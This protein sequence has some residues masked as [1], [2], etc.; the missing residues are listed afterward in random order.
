[1]NTEPKYH[2]VHE[3]LAFRKNNLLRVNSEYQRGAVWGDAQKR[4]LVDSVLRGYPIPLF[5]LHIVT[6]KM[7]SLGGSWL[8]VIDGQQ[9][10][11]ALDEFLHD[12][13]ALFD[14]IKDDKQARFPNFIKDVPCTW[15]RKTFSQLDSDDKARFLN[16]KLQV[17]EIETDNPNEARDLFIRLQAGLP[18]NSQ[19]KRDAWPG[20]LTELVLRLAGKGNLVGKGGHDF[21]KKFV[22]NTGTDRGKGRQLCAQ[23]LML[24]ISRR[25]HR[26]S[27]PDIGSR[28]L[29]EFYYR[30]LDFELQGQVATR[31]QAVLDR[32]ANI[33]GAT[34][35][36]KPLKG[37]EAIGVILLIDALMD[38]YTKG[39]EDIFV[40]A[41]LRF[42]QCVLND[43]ASRYSSE[44]GP[45]W[46][47]YDALTRVDSDRGATI[48][49]RHGFFCMV[50]VAFLSVSMKLKDE[51]RIFG[52]VER[53]LIFL[54]AGRKC[55]VCGGVVAWDDHEI[56]H[57]DPHA[58]G[59]PTKRT[60][61]ALVHK[62]CHPRSAAEVERLRAT[63]EARA[64]GPPA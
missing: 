21:F 36:I 30:N 3:I 11:N 35:R 31:F 15:G 25:E 45:F 22:S 27:W 50:M 32:T 2:A 20:H 46:K 64:K 62:G 24:F 7:G 52:E 60:N 19:E 12:G 39:W 9:R 53:E 8:E 47:S 56:H 61:A 33:F 63:I 4:K 58:N 44:P 18:L 57:V 41:F 55:A 51:L 16:T 59:G 48:Q 34:K 29:D 1:V 40:D 54:E 37:H 42:R 38:D 49:V 28:A 13:F 23:L 26:E 5:Y 10:L 43:K 6:N 14:P 17:V